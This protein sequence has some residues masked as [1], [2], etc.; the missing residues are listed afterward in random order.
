MSWEPTIGKWNDEE[1]YVM[2]KPLWE[3]LLS[4]ARP[5]P[6]ARELLEVLTWF[7]RRNLHGDYYRERLTGCF[8]R[9]AGVDL[10][11]H[12]GA[13]LRAEIHRL[14]ETGG[15]LRGCAVCLLEHAGIDGEII[16]D[17]RAAFP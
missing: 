14:T 9:L 16:D 13:E 2:I 12:M 7:G 1:N 5:L 15:T 10:R 8:L 17:F 3:Q 11:V 4:L 6:G